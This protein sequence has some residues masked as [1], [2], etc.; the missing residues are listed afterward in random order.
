MSEELNFAKVES[1]CWRALCQHQVSERQM[2]VAA[3]VIR[4]SFVVG[5]PYLRLDYAVELARLTGLTKGNAHTTVQTLVRGRALEVSAD[6]KLYTF[7]PPSKAWPWLFAPRVDA[8]AANDLE[9]AIVWANTGGDRQGQLF[10]P[11]ADREFTEALQIELMREALLERH[12][13]ATSQHFPEKDRQ[14]KP[15]ERDRGEPDGPLGTTP[16]SCGD[17][18]VEEFA[19][20]GEPH[21]SYYFHPP[22]PPAD[23]TAKGSR[24][25]NPAEQKVPDSGTFT[26]ESSRIGNP[27]LRALRALVSSKEVVPNTKSLSGLSAKFPNREPMTWQTHLDPGA[28][29][30]EILSWLRGV[31]GWAFMEKWGGMWRNSVRD[32]R[33]GVVETI[34]NFKLR[35]QSHGMPDNPGAWLRDQYNR[36]ARVL[37]KEVKP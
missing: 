22:R 27:P 28:S 34:A 24:F 20:A 6:G 1:V 19:T 3:T 2:V 36:F 5:E 31:L 12:R 16:A 15:A 13:W 21:A 25:G 4:L 10:A 14:P 33:L 8:R 18:G 11:D 7:L 17:T 9:G 23:E 30:E 35:V 37:K 26:P 32:C 29:E